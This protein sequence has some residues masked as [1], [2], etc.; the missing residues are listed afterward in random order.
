MLLNWF[1]MSLYWLIL[2]VSLMLL[3]RY[4]YCLILFMRLI[5]LNRF[6]ITLY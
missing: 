3:K 2:L 1:L 6:A 5:V 4:L